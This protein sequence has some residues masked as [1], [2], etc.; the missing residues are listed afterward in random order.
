MPPWLGRDGNRPGGSG[1]AVRAA[2]SRPYEGERWRVAMTAGRI[3]R[4]VGTPPYGP[5]RTWAVGAA[6]SRPGRPAIPAA[7]PSNTVGRHA[8]MPPWLGRDGN[9][10]GSPGGAVRAAASRPYEGKA[11]FCPDRPDRLWVQGSPLL[12]G[13]AVGAKTAPRQR[14]M[15]DGCVCGARLCLL[16]GLPP[17]MG[18]G[19]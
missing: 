17:Q 4:G 1:G 9:R 18:Q 2:A 13:R 15:E 14:A 7:P 10:P 3:W 6:S 5:G 8:H 19:S 12:A 11:G 16:Y